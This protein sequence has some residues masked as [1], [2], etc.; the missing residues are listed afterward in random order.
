[1]HTRSIIYHDGTGRYII[2]STTGTDGTFF[3]DGTG[4]KFCFHDGMGRYGTR[5]FSLLHRAQ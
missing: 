5:I 4:G 1:M 3:F 2:S